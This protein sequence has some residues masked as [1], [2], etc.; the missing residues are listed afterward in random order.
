[1]VSVS[2]GANQVLQG[3]TLL[4]SDVNDNAPTFTNLPNT[5][6]VHE[7]VN[8]GYNVFVV[9]AED[10]DAAF[11]GVVTYSISEDTPGPFTINAFTGTVTVSGNLDYETDEVYNIKIIAKDS[12]TNSLSTEEYL[13]INIVD[14][15]DAGPEFLNPPYDTAIDEG[16]PVNTVV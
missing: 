13:T 15:Q 7:N 12:A 9:N 16:T 2:D 3:G 6:T 11:A 5:T 14:V 1:M 4:V 8:F 10:R